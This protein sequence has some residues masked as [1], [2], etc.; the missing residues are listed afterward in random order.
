MISDWLYRLRHMDNAQLELVLIR[1]DAVPR[2]DG[3]SLIAIDG[4]SGAGKT[5][6][7]TQLAHRLAAQVVQVDDFYRSTSERTVAD[8]AETGWEFDLGRLKEQ[9]LVPLSAGRPGS[10][11]R[12]DWPTDHLADWRE[13]HPGI[14]FVEGVYSLRSD[15]RGFYSFSIWVACNPATCLGRMLEREDSRPILQLEYW[16]A[17]EASYLASQRPDSAANIIV[18]GE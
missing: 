4:P 8:R 11:Q 9:V 12:Y 5:T 3:R 7:S 2:T 14:V 10:Y 15:L 16:M 18:A 6:L 17:E 1:L 13:V